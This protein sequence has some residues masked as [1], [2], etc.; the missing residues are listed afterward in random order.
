[1]NAVTRSPLAAAKVRLSDQ[2]VWLLSVL[3]GAGSPWLHIPR[4]SRGLSHGARSIVPLFLSGELHLGKLSETVVVV[5]NAP[6]DRP[7]VLVCHLVR[8][9]AS[10]LC[11]KAPM[12]RVPNE[13]SG[14]HCQ[15]PFG[16]Q[17]PPAWLSRSSIVN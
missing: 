7:G 17:P 12:P 1:M 16:P 11:T 8:N 6:H 14:C 9:R 10:F 13:L 4:L 2:S 5:G 15:D 3:T